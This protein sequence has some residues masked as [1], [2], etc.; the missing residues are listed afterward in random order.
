VKKRT[1]E[2]EDARLI[3]ESANQAKSNFFAN[4]S[5]E[6]RTPLNVIIGFSEALVSGIYGEMKDEHAEYI[7]HILQSG[8]HLLLLIDSIMELTKADTGN[9][10]L[11]YTEC[12]IDN[13]INNAVGMFNE[14]AKKHRIGL[15]GE[16]EEGLLTCLVDQNKIKYVIVN[17]LS[18]ALKNTGDGGSVS[19]QARKV[20]RDSGSGV[21]EKGPIPS[22]Q[23]PTPDRDF[24]EIAVFNTGPLIPEEKRA[25]LFSP[26]HQTDSSL[27]GSS[28]GLRVGLALCKRF[29][30]LHGGRIWIESLPAEGAETTDISKQCAKAT[31]NRF[32]FVL[33][34][35]PSDDKLR[36]NNSNEDENIQEKKTRLS[37][38]PEEG[39]QNT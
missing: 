26:F 34:R 7:N 39:G 17:L 18:N 33:P 16:I 4:M 23:V 36:H 24:I 1:L 8:M 37:R 30:Q 27:T 29:V 10:S 32:I 15:H 3:A 6:L 9:M 14:K 38:L 22:P 5:H 31:G 19:V 35:K 21:S 25:S 13:I 28:E 2:L 12:S 11:D 20:I